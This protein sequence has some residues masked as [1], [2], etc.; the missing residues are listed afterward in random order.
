MRFLL[1]KANF[2]KKSLGSLPSKEVNLKSI[3]VFL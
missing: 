2:Y 3:L 1:E